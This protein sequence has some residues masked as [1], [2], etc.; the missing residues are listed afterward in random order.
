MYSLDNTA[1]K[2]IDRLTYERH[3]S[4]QREAQ[5]TE[6][7]SAIVEK[8]LEKLPESERTVVTLHY[9]GEMT[10]KEIGRFLG[11]SVNTIHSRLH[12][13]RR[14]LQEE[15]ELLVQE[16]LGSV[17]ISENLIHNI[18]RQVADLKPTPPPTTKPVLPWIAFGAAAIL[19]VILL[20]AG[21]RHLTRF[22]KP[23]S[24]EAASEPTIE[25][26]DAPIVLDI[27]SK[28]DVRNQ[29]GRDASVSEKSITGS[30]TSQTRLA[31]N[32]QTDADKFS[33]SQWIQTNRP[34]GGIIY[35]IFLTSNKNLYAAAPTGIYRLAADTTVW[36]RINT[37]IPIT[38]F[39]MP[40]AE[41]DGNLYIVS[42]DKIYVSADNGETWDIFCD[43][44]KGNSIGLIIMDGAQELSSHPSIVMYLAIHNKGVFRSTDAGTQWNLLENGLVNANIH[45]VTAIGNTV[46]AGTNKGLYG[47]NSDTWQRLAAIP[48]ESIYALT[49][50]GNDLYVT[51][52]PNLFL[53]E[54]T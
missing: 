18:M 29:T 11:V 19:I 54:T 25:I 10:T 51:T 38:K 41:H 37:D 28:P 49:A 50:F 15:E 20:A 5:A 45:A 24:F 33:T 9:L 39:R 36:T 17:Q 34:Y 42:D 53:H 27:D 6:R 8:L 31:S 7:R 2:E 23:Y 14:R 47:L 32:T 40:M 35:G 43:R 22:Q 26:I 44:P 13:A 52:G 46:F 3:I 48:S 1:V 30:Q 4:E 12:R 16:V 21:N